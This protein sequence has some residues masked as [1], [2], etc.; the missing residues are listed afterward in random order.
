MDRLLSVA[1]GEFDNVV[2]DL[3]AR[4]NPEGTPLYHQASMV[5]LV[6]QSGIPELRNANRL[7]GQIFAHGGPPLEIVLNRSESRS[8]NISEEHITKA[9]G[10]T[11]KWK[12]PNDHA[13]VRKMQVEAS[14][15]V[16]SEN[17]ISRVIRG[18]ADSV[19]GKQEAVT[20]KKKRFGL[21]S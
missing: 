5:Y 14:P 13:L 9:L 4:L 18:M 6:T 19:T 7:I 17:S 11:V 16:L 20:Q 15:L 10:R 12:I 1:R 8:L 21:F 2:V 3:G